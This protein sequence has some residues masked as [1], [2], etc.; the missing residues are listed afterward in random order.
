M[1]PSSS[2]SHPHAN[3][4]SE[5]N[6]LKQYLQT[7][8]RLALIGP[9]PTQTTS[10]LQSYLDNDSKTIK[11]K[12]K[13]TKTT[14]NST[15]SSHKRNRTYK[16]NLVKRQKVEEDRQNSG[17]GGIGNERKSTQKIGDG[18]GMWDNVNSNIGPKTMKSNQDIFSS[19]TLDD[20]I[21]TTCTST[22]TNNTF[23][24]R[25]R[26]E[27]ISK[28]KYVSTAFTKKTKSIPPSHLPSSNV[29]QKNQNQS[30]LEESEE[31]PSNLITKNVTL[32]SPGIGNKLKSI[33]FI[34]KT[35]RN[36]S[37]SKSLGN[38]LLQGKS[39]TS[40]HHSKKFV[41]KS[42][43][44]DTATRPYKVESDKNIIL[45]TLASS[46]V[47][48]E[49][50]SQSDNNESSSNP[51]LPT[52]NQQECKELENNHP[53]L[54]P[55]NSKITSISTSSST[56][57][58]VNFN[59][60]EQ[61][62]GS[63][64]SKKCN[65]SNN[66]HDIKII[67]KRKTVNN[68]NFVKLNLR[69]SAGS[70]R[71]ARNIKKKKK[72]DAINKRRQEYNDRKFTKKVDDNEED[73]ENATA[74]TNNSYQTRAKQAH[75]I[76]DAI[77][78]I[79]DYLDGTF[80]SKSSI[81][82]TDCKINH[83]DDNAESSQNV[84]NYPVCFRHNRQCKLLIVKKNTTGN[85]GRKFFACSMPKG[86]QCNFF[87]WEDDTV[88]GTKNGLLEASS[89][90]G[91]IAR[92]VSAHID[93]FKSLTVPELRIIAKQKHLESSGKKNALIVRLSVWVRDQICMDQVVDKNMRIDIISED[94]KSDKS[95]KLQLAD[96]S[97]STDDDDEDEDDDSTSSEELE[98]S[99]I[100]QKV[101]LLHAPEE[102]PDE[103][104]ISQIHPVKTSLHQ[105]LFDLFGYSNFRDGQEWAIK[106]C[107]AHKKTLLVAPTG[108]GKSLCYALP[109]ALMDG[110]CIVV[111]PLIS[112]IE[113]QLRHL[114]PRIP[115]ATL[116]G[117][118]SKRN[119]AL[120][121]DDLL[122]SRLKVLFVSPEKLTSAA[123]QRLLRPKYNIQTKTYERQLPPVSLLCLDE[124]H[125]LSQVGLIV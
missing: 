91:F 73:G 32:N 47:N 45:P 36:K 122:N 33:N 59:I 50:H 89:H 66:H 125:C 79:D 114:P 111:S 86:E 34:S 75:S 38:I 80:H 18:D 48:E 84:S 124:A 76:H 44:I 92:Q 95:A 74:P 115:S 52:L 93:R 101:S 51:L 35:Q 100:D 99:G 49:G 102:E 108:M 71:G 116:S 96:D 109:A 37:A 46:T 118:I 6:K 103:S 70:C 30:Q 29:F 11:R 56:I 120:I 119:M 1:P 72:W 62:Q 25:R 97:D 113:D 104:E 112:L 10:L 61:L 21:T 12:S 64:Q 14:S 39:S 82:E 24:N 28:V 20:L 121:I 77:D 85:K 67:K 40:M 16:S 94:K 87:Q 43:C 9:P 17:D 88:E 26:E 58:S 65:E 63:N 78:P 42:T 53:I 98:I 23:H 106:R 19:G 123:F 54:P 117:N 8:K 60:S 27:P 55:L 4:K 41:S 90:S 68:D 107:L 5:S 110:I 15:G 22:N 81:R 31:L 105:S 2:S 13:V 69:N 3:S 83:D 7:K 57:T